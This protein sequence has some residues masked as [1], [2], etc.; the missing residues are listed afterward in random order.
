MNWSPPGSSIHGIFQA[1]VLEWGAIA[2]SKLTS[3]HILNVGNIQPNPATNSYIESLTLNGNMFGDGNFM[4]V[5][6]VPIDEILDSTLLFTAMWGHS[7]KVAIWKPER[8]PSQEA[9]LAGWHLDVGLLSFRTVTKQTVSRW[10][11][12]SPN[13]WSFVMAAQSDKTALS[14]HPQLP[15]CGARSRQEG[16][17]L[18]PFFLGCHVNFSV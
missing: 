7:G 14:S 6:R 18:L 17:C 9:K 10:L 4:E 1:R 5:I 12:K 11:F 16:G 3:Y 8:E 2:F 15:T 13:L